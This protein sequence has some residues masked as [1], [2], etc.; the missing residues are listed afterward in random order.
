[1]LRKT[2]AKYRSLPIE[3][4]IAMTDTFGSEEEM[5]A[6]FVARADAALWKG[7]DGSR[8]VR[9]FFESTCSEGRADWVWAKVPDRAPNLTAENATLLRQPACSVILASLNKAAVRTL[10]YIRRRAGLTQQ[11]LNRT[12][13]LLEEGYLISRRKN[14]FTL[15]EDGVVPCLECVAFEFKLNNWRRAYSQARRYRTFSNR[16]FVVLQP[17]PAKRAFRQKEVF[18]RAAVGLI[19][20]GLGSEPQVL[21]QSRKCRPLNKASAIRAWG[22]LAE[23]GMIYTSRSKSSI[24][25]DHSTR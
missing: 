5:R 17:A 14:G 11:T 13:R 6:D 20:H 9:H 10:P 2:E 12:L 1:M 8:L 7:V 22:E 18:R 21:I 4:A 23:R 25:S 3:S 24:A 15:T 19:S 16:T